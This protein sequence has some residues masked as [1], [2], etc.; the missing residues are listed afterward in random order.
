MKRTAAL[1]LAIIL[2]L[3]IFSS[4]S[5]SYDNTPCQDVILAMTKEEKSLPAGKYYSLSATNGEEEYLSPSLIAALF[6][7]GS[8]PKIAD[9]WVDGALFLSLMSHPCEFAVIFCRDRD[10]AED[11]ARLFN[12]RIDAIKITKTDP[13]YREM[14][15]NAIV[16]VRGNYAILIVSSDP[17]DAMR[18]AKKSIGI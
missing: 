12:S 1:F 6:G 15:D 18:A 2:I 13:S 4:C 8:Y 17:T 16:A 10:T 5:K 14:I 7:N 9:G 3:P 11:T